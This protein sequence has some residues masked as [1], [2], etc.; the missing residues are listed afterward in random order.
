MSDNTLPISES[1]TREEVANYL[2]TT[3]IIKD[4]IKNIL[5]NEYIWGDI[6]PVL[7]EKHLAGIGF[8]FGP[9]KRIMK[10]V[11]ANI[12]KFKEREMTEKIMA[13]SSKEEV[14][15]FFEKSLEFTG[16]LN[17]LD[18]KGLLELDE[19]GMKKLGLKIRTKNKIN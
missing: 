9:R 7:S 1:S 14:K 17:N 19:E 2:L 11:A 4:N 15:D 5:I 3:N 8:K 16:E 12:S 10:F 6:L 13:N 18:G